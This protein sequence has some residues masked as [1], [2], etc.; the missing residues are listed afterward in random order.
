MGSFPSVSPDNLEAFKTLKAKYEALKQE[1]CD[2]DEIFLA[3]KQV[4][5][6]Q[7]FYFVGNFFRWECSFLLF[8]RLRIRSLFVYPKATLVVKHCQLLLRSRI[9]LM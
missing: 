1:G 8:I 3:L 4:T 7:M 5:L 9:R 6:S 2:D